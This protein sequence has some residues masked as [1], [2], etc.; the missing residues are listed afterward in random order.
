[1]R[2]L[3]D[4]HI[5]LWAA[6]GAG[7]L[8][9][10]AARV[11]EDPANTLLVSAA[12]IWEIAVKHAKGNLQV[13]PRDARAAFRLAGFGELPVSG[14]HTEAVATLPAHA[15]HADPFDRLMVAQAIQEGMPLLS[16]DPKLWRYHPTLMLQG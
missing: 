16:A 10:Q 13:H 7:Q 9:A 4:T 12:A 11:I 15:D 5:A 1:M 8:S 6:E 14:D 2:V 3:L